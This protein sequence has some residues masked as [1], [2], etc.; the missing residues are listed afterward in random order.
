MQGSTA[1]PTPCGAALQASFPLILTIPF[2][3]HCFMQNAMDYLLLRE[4]KLLLLFYMI[5][6][7]S[8]TGKYA[9][10]YLGKL[11]NM[12]LHFCGML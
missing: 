11:C 4:I 9:K 10:P 8:S 3:S 2:S 5:G 12:I 6:F 1:Q 7:F